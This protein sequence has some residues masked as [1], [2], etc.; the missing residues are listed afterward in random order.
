MTTYPGSNEVMW[1][2]RKTKKSAHTHVHT[3]HSTRVANENGS[4]Q[5]ALSRFSLSPIK[6]GITYNVGH[7]EKS[8]D[9]EIVF[10][11]QY[12]VYDDCTMSV[13]FYQRQ[14]FSS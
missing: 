2:Y 8:A 10:F 7:C 14:F 4:S 3:A 11:F 1:F 6:K 13:H 12:I 5:Y 9:S